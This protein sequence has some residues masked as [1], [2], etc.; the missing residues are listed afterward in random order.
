M[1]QQSVWGSN[2]KAIVDYV[3]RGKGLKLIWESDPKAER[4]MEMLRPLRDLAT[5]ESIA[6]SFAGTKRRFYVLDIASNNIRE[7]QAQVR[8]LPDSLP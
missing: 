1:T 4:I 2:K 7:F 5:E 3:P 6:F 8:A